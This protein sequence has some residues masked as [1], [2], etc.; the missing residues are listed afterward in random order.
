MDDDKWREERIKRLAKEVKD[1]S[2]G[3]IA[4]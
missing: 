1:L 2:G 3:R 4:G